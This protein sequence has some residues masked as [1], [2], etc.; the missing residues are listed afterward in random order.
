[1]KKTVIAAR[2]NFIVAKMH[3]STETTSVMG[4]QTVPMDG[5]KDSV[6]CTEWN[7]H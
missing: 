5:M 1:M 6:V 7:M 2:I 3:A 4:D